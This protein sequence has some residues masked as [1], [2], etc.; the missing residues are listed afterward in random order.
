LG[1]TT[2]PI[3]LTKKFPK[4]GEEKEKEI[5]K[6]KHPVHQDIL[7]TV[8]NKRAGSSA[9]LIESEA[10]AQYLPSN[11]EKG[12]KMG[13][14]GTGDISPGR[15]TSAARKGGF[16]ASD[17]GGNYKRKSTGNGM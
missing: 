17:D 14:N 4:H 1:P 13:K 15:R 16:A 5:C 12:N 3:D 6:N 10:Y 11:G 2:P 9:P 7:S 8:E